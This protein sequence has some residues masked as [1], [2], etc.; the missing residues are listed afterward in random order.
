MIFF[1]LIL[2]SAKVC[3]SDFKYR[4]I[5]N[6]SAL[7]I[8]ILSIIISIQNGNFS[9]SSIKTSIIILVVGFL[10]TKIKILGSGDIKL[11]S[12]F[13]LAIYDNMLIPLFIMIGFFG[14]VQ[15]S[16]EFLYSTIKGQTKKF[17]NGIP[18]GITISISSLLTIYL[19]IVL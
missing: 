12:A 7:I 14:G 1:I 5:S 4:K 9:Y 18:Y 19:S 15:V 17:T 6:N 10:L 3:Y 2:A 13:S 11:I 16:I 8:G